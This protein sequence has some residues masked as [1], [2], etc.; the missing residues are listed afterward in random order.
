[1]SQ[2]SEVLSS[3][4]WAHGGVRGCVCVRAGERGL[5]PGLLHRLS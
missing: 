5:V 2:R 4:I 3:Q 1:M